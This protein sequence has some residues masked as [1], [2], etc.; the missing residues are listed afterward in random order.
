MVLDIVITFLDS[1]FCISQNINNRHT[2]MKNK[3]DYIDVIIR[4]FILLGAF[5]TIYWFIQ[6]FFGG[7]PTLSQF[8]AGFIFV[9]IGLLVHLYYKFGLFDNFVNNTFPRFERSIE[10]SFDRI[11]EDI[12]SI[13]KKL[14]IKG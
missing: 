8:N 11:K 2:K 3:I 12:E 10:K 5:L 14:Q 9:I 6:L 4:I 7:S 1:V 13:K